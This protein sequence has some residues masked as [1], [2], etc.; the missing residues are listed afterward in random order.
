MSPEQLAERYRD[1]VRSN[2]GQLRD[3]GGDPSEQM[4]SQLVG[5]AEEH[6]REVGVI[7][8]KPA[9][10]CPPDELDEYVGE[11][12]QDPAFREA[13]EAADAEPKPAPRRRAPARGRAK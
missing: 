7:A 9:D 3:S 4:I 11:A 5:I 8:V 2:A 13:Y 1:V 10:D 12:M 6:A